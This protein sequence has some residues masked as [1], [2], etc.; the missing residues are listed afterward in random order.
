MLQKKKKQSAPYV[1]QIAVKKFLWYE[2]GLGCQV[3]HP[4]T[5]FSHFGFL[6]NLLYLAS[7][8]TRNRHC[9]LFL[10]QLEEGSYLL[11]RNSGAERS[12]VKEPRSRFQDKDGS[13]M[14]LK[15]ERRCPKKKKKKA[16]PG[17]DIQKLV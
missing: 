2:Y 4:K 5:F 6:S 11:T 14:C 9:Y 3:I 8:L 17:I 13:K 16:S 1:P 12:Q 7:F 10:D 15:D